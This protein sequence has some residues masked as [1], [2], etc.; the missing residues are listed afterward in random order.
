MTS[1]EEK[2]PHW[3]RLVDLIFGY[4]Y[5]ISYSWGDGRQYAVELRKA[6]EPYRLK[7]FLDVE[8][9]A[10]GSNWHF[11]ARRALKKTTRL[12]LV[13]SP[14]ALKSKAVGKELEIFLG[15]RRHIIP[16]SFN[17]SLD[18]INTPAIAIGDLLGPDIIRINE[19][20]DAL[21]SG[22]SDTVVTELANS[23]K[24]LTQDQKRIRLLSG[25]VLLF[26]MIAI[27]AGWQWRDARSSLLAT[28]EEY[29]RSRMAAGVKNFQAGNVEAG[30]H[31][32]LSAYLTA[33][34]AKLAELNQSA[35]SLMASWSE[36][37]G[38]RL[39]TESSVTWAGFALGNQRVITRD[40][41]C[42][43][44][45]DAD[46]GAPVGERI[47]HRGFGTNDEIERRWGAPGMVLSNKGDLMLSTADSSVSIWDVK[48][49]QQIGRS[50]P[51]DQIIRAA[52]FSPDGRLI[53]TGDQAGKVRLWDSGTGM[54]VGQAMAHQ[55][56]I[57]TL[58][59]SPDSKTLATG[60]GHVGDGMTAYAGY[61]QLW[62]VET[63]QARWTPMKGMPYQGLVSPVDQMAFSTNGKLF[64]FGDD[65]NA[66]V[67]DVSTPSTAVR[68][69]LL[70]YHLN[71]DGL[72]FTADGSGVFAS[73]GAR[74][75][76][77]WQASSGKE[78]Q[79]DINAEPST[80]D[81][82]LIVP[83]ISYN[84][85]GDRALSILKEQLDYASDHSTMIRVDV[86]QTRT[87]ADGKPLGRPMNHPGEVIY[88][89]FVSDDE[90]VMTLSTDGIM[91][92][93]DAFT[94]APLAEY[95]V[96]P[97]MLQYRMHELQQR[98]RYAG[99]YLRFF[100]L[101]SDSSLL[102]TFSGDSAFLRRLPAAPAGWAH[103][104]QVV[105]E[106]RFTPDGKVAI[107]G[108]WD[109]TASFWD[110]RTGLHSREPIDHGGLIW[111]IDTTRD[112]K[113]LATAGGRGEYS[114]EANVHLW[115]IASGKRVGNPI[116]HAGQDTMSIARFSPDGERLLTASMKEIALWNVADQKAI[117]GPLVQT[118]E[119]DIAQFSP[120]GEIFISG[121]TSSVVTGGL[122]EYRFFNGKTG[123]PVGNTIGLKGRAAAVAF[124]PDGETILIA[125]GTTARSWR[126]KTGMPTGL[127]LPHDRDITSLA[128]SLDG[129]FILTGSWDRS[130]KLWDARTGKLAGG[131]LV[132]SDTVTSLAFDKSANFF[133]TGTMPGVVQ[134]WDTQT[135]LPLGATR[136]FRSGA[137]DGISISADA[138][139]VAVN[140][141][142]SPM[143]RLERQLADEPERLMLWIETQTRK[144]RDNN[145]SLQHLDY[146]QWLAGRLRLT[147]LG[148]PPNLTKP[149]PA[150]RAAALLRKGLKLLDQQRV[151]EA[152][153]AYRQARESDSHA[154]I[155]ALLLDRLC[156][157]GSTK[158]FAKAVLP[159]CEEAVRL[160]PVNKHYLDS[161]GLARA[162]TGDFDGAIG[163]FQ[164]YIDW[165]IQLLDRSFSQSV[166]NRITERRSWIEALKRGESPLTPGM[167]EELSHMRRTGKPIKGDTEL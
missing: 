109:Y 74:I 71:L 87:T 102:V 58:K 65:H 127:A 59:F 160:N 153:A 136:L 106:P 29:A 135:L 116:V 7:C 158:G 95:S 159:E 121:T 99:G 43:Q 83:Y 78:L 114:R 67:W 154:Y 54:S 157:V 72:G 119:V 89:T 53:A 28:Q 93:W 22:P 31:E 24:I 45:W 60:F 61:A 79:V 77:F 5:F 137:V 124:S 16:I 27:L 161:R 23:F 21:S 104:D 75:V 39:A 103:A 32:L 4:D 63:Q 19:T 36:A 73:S 55:H 6:L 3:H 88:A 17:G 156:W 14:G 92:L 122:G 15:L 40:E 144:Y 149:A 115:D 148:G 81:K 90:W 165:L 98:E 33:R 100:G 47:P 38:L 142:Y 132:H 150:E 101:S 134:R 51:H 46:N 34:E 35:R 138:Q 166:S 69:A 141:Q 110:V 1:D 123:Q 52:A 117:A 108:S 147:E 143:W 9:F 128:W 126:V 155:P 113:L 80:Y 76:K 140:D 146:Q 70:G 164:V 49:G 66:Q 42:A 111:F 107:T 48:T 25:A 26:I 125:D 20:A 84:L 56:E 97:S 91:R 44:I 112:G 30:M 145:G 151:E 120:D 133:V 85:N 139:A 62:D 11:E 68:S 96:V 131:A 163:D 130:A 152:I 13:G 94:G 64:V 129:R 37:S 10:K 82:W 41:T 162:L 8:E 2:R 105:A 50:L 18:H 167:L 86:V 57:Y 118:G 12:I